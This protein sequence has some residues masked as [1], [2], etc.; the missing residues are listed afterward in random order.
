[1]QVQDDPARGTD[2]DLRHYLRVIG[3]RKW[4]ILAVAIVVGVAATAYAFTKEEQ[5]RATGEMLLL[6]PGPLE[7]AAEGFSDEPDRIIANEIEILGSL[8]MRQAVADELGEDAIPVEAAAPGDNDVITL[9][10]ESPDPEAAADAVNAYARTYE[11]IRRQRT[12]AAL[13]AEAQSLI[14]ERRAQVATLAEVNQPLQDLQARIATTPPGPELD[15]LNAQAATIEES[16][17]GAREAINGEI[18]RLDSE[19]QNTQRAMRN[20]SGGVNYLNP[21]TVPREPF[22][23]QPKKDLLVGLVV[24]LLLGLGAAFVWEQLDDAVR[25]RA[26]ADR[27]T[28]G[29]AVLGLIPKVTGWRNRTDTVLVCRD[30]PHSGAAESYRSLVTS[31]EFLTQAGEAKVLLFT[32]PGASEGKTT[33]VANVGI[34]LSE[35][36]HRTLIVDGDLRRPRLHHFFG[37][38]NTVGLTTVL[39]DR[40]DIATA[41]V[42]IDGYEH[43]SVVPAGPASPNPAEML[44]TDVTEAALLK[45]AESFDLVLIDSP[46][47]LPV[48]DA[49]VLARHADAAVLLAAADSTSRRS[50]TRAVE[51]LRQVEA[52]LRGLV[53]NGV[54]SG[55]GYEY[56][57]YAESDEGGR[58]KKRRSGRRARRSGPT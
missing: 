10:A 9:V 16:I 57:Y 25:G 54:G 39:A 3:R 47:V 28:G 5:Y 13:R 1:M 49:L 19:V 6:A 2:L 37:I 45:L 11:R 8:E 32:S 21:A 34:A 22:Y 33:T 4:V 48:A 58:R 46:P 24:G 29:L 14:Q 51:A 38:P 36:G 20:P 56:G 40:I 44:R 27:A 18:S 23:P 42:P 30:E 52:P 31:L 43:L 12:V 7:A 41:V 53:L 17:A 15:A 26:D 35:A 55:E 50:L